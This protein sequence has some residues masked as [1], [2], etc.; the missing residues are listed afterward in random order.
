MAAVRF[1]WC[2]L[3]HHNPWKHKRCAS[4][5]AARRLWAAKDFVRGRGMTGPAAA[6]AAANLAELGPDVVNLD[7]RRPR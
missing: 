1:S 3:M 5:T 7:E 2:A 6:A 4:C